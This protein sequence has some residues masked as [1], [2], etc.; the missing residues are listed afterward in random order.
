MAV[1]VRTVVATH[2]LYSKLHTHPPVGRIGHDE[3]AGHPAER[4]HH[5]RRD[6][7]DNATDRIAHVLGAGDDQTAAQQDD[8]GEDVVQPKD[9][10]VGLH[11]L[12]LEVGLQAAQ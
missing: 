1:A 10:V 7:V 3:R 12:R 8:S 5:M 11:L 2:A 6:A 9:G 4:V